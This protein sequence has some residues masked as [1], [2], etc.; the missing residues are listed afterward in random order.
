MNITHNSSL[1][2]TKA[3]CSLQERV[4][5]SDYLFFKF[6]NSNYLR[7]LI[8][9]GIFLNTL[10]V[11]VLSRPRLSNKSTTIFFLRF[12]A[13]FDIL[14][15]T[16]KYVRVE[17]N[18]QSRLYVCMGASISITMW[19]IVLMSV[20]KAIAVSYPLKSS[21]WLTQKRVSYICYLTSLIL[22]L[23]N[24]SFISFAEQ[25]RTRHNKLF[26]GL[27]QDKNPLIFDSITASILPM[28]LTTA[29][30]IIIAVTLHYVSRNTFNW[31][32]KKGKSDINRSELDIT[33]S[34]RSPSPY[35]NQ[36]SLAAPLTNDTSLASK[37]RTSAQVTRMLFAVTLSL[38]LFNL[39]NSVI[40]LFSKRIN[41]KGLFTGRD[42]L[43]ISNYEIKLYQIDF[44]LSVIQDILSDLP[45][46]VNFFLYCLAGKKFRSIILD[47]VQHFLVGIHLIK[48]KQKRYVQA[49]HI[50]STDS[51]NTTRL[52][53]SHRHGSLTRSLVQLQQL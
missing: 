38:I 42:C 11:I 18:Y 10:C 26:C 36:T 3:N 27:N 43:T 35:P 19:T 32:S 8:G 39:P 30:N 2:T 29:A 44:M 51:G 34:K 20:D 41:A 22:L 14:A 15:I 17:L 37:R 7:I 23:A 12:L 31:P 40:Y 24:L 33:K 21:I 49:N 46:I 1:L 4:Y 50:I 5:S 28:T 9:P 45:H 53:R 25:G 13:I 47:E 16:L 48:R 52:N 6:L